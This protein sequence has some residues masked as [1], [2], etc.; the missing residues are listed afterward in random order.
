M[1]VVEIS[2]SN[3]K[4][5]T[6]K[7]VH[8][9]EVCAQ[10]MRAKLQAGDSIVISGTHQRGTIIARKNKGTDIWLILLSG[11]VIELSRD[12]F[13][14]ITNMLHNRRKRNFERMNPDGCYPGSECLNC[15]L[16][17]WYV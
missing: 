1:N 14:K 12:Y 8:L 5:K 17:K 6:E 15:E 9:P 3:L 7:S 16:K 10:I 2:L 11:N 4:T 13:V